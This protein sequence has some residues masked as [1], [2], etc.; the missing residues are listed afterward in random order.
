MLVQ[1][2]AKNVGGVL[3]ETQCRIW[4]VATHRNPQKLKNFCQCLILK[5]AKKKCSKFCCVVTLH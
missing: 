4:T 2:T 3:Y 5:P 1:D